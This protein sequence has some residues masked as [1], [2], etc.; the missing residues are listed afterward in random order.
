MRP[1]AASSGVIGCANVAPPEQLVLPPKMM[2]SPVT[3]GRVPATGVEPG[4]RAVMRR[5]GT[6]QPGDR[7]AGD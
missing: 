6:G 4:S 1:Q 7:P 3:A 5:R 2:L